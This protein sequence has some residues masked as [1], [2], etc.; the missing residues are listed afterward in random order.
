MERW[1]PGPEPQCH[2]LLPAYSAK[3]GEPL[4]A[5]APTLPIF[6]PSTKKSQ[7]LINQ[8][9][10]QARQLRAPTNQNKGQVEELANQSKGHTDF[11]KPLE[12]GEELGAE[13]AQ[14]GVEELKVW[15]ISDPPQ[16]D[17]CF[18]L[19]LSFH[20]SQMGRQLSTACGFGNF[21]CI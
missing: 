15:V 13:Y 17:H 8:N 11:S 6:L 12:G 16:M 3:G 1:L 5:G 10:G 20:I 7:K 14:I 2:S 18:F 19:S 4:L 9:K 21:S